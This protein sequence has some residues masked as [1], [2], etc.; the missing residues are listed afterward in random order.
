MSQGIDFYS[1]NNAPVIYIGP[2]PLFKQL[3]FVLVL[4]KVREPGLLKHYTI[5]KIKECFGKTVPCEITLC[6]ENRNDLT[7]H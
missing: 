6:D 1:R 5:K 2:V 3:A 7:S 4:D